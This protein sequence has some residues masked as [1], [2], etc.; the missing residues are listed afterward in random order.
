[1]GKQIWR[2]VQ[3]ILDHPNNGQGHG[4]AKISTV[5]VHLGCGH[6]RSYPKSKA[7]SGTHKVRCVQC[8]K[9]PPHA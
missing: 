9:E 3:H 1:M 2:P 5:F 8:E 6:V 4:G 7:P